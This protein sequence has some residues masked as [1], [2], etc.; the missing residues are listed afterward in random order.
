MT[1]PS[2]AKATAPALS[3]V[4]GI[5]KILISSTAWH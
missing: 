4:V 5:R 1:S 2:T 3:S